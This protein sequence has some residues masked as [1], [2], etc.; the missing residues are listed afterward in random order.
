MQFFAQTSVDGLTGHP[1]LLV[2]HVILNRNSK[3]HRLRMPRSYR[4]SHKSDKEATG[5]H[6]SRDDRS[7]THGPNHR[8]TQPPSVTTPGI[9]PGRG[10]LA[11]QPR[12]RVSTQGGISLLV[13]RDPGYQPRAGYPCSPAAAPLRR[14]TLPHTDGAGQ[15]PPQPE[16][17]LG[18][19]SSSASMSTGRPS[20]SRGGRTR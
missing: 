9:N 10:I 3:A 7:P 2:A 18:D 4:Q 5:M 17:E 14:R 19:R 6:A 15:G 1:Q 20:G 13:S 12:P 11:R 16:L 8:C